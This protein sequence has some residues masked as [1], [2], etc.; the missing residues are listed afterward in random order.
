M[1]PDMRQALP[2]GVPQTPI[3]EILADVESTAG[4]VGDLQATAGKAMPE[5]QSSNLVFLA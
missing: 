5:I 1:Q 3:E 4:M 2:G